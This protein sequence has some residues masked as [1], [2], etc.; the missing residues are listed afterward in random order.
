MMVAETKTLVVMTVL[1]MM[2]MMIMIMMQ[3]YGAVL[4]GC[5]A[6]VGAAFLAHALNSI[7]SGIVDE[8]EDYVAWNVISAAFSLIWSMAEM[9]VCCIAALV[10]A[11]RMTRICGINLVPMDK[12]RAMLAGV[13]SS[14]DDGF[15]NRY[16]LLVYALIYMG[17]RGITKFFIKLLVKKVAPRTFVK[18]ADMAPLV[19]EVLINVLFNFIT[20]RYAMSEVMICSI[21]PSAT[22]E[23]GGYV[24]TEEAC[25]HQ[26]AHQSTSPD[27][28]R[29]PAVIQQSAGL[30]FTVWLSGF[31]FTAVQQASVIRAPS[32]QT[33]MKLVQ[34]Q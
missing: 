18:A 33:C 3:R 26:P 16:L 1:M 23:V 22:V 28:R 12:E 30:L 8:E 11:V 31:G 24:S 13:N 21:G 4:A 2:M 19:I 25:S 32:E 20:V 10:A 17:S 34:W 14:A 7:T 15:L 29:K 9:V 5:L 6:G 27:L